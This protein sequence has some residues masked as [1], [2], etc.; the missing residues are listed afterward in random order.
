[1]F[2]MGGRSEKKT[3]LQRQRRQRRREQ[4]PLRRA[5]LLNKEEREGTIRVLVGE[6]EQE[7]KEGRKNQ[8]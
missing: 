5:S 1:M 6:P 7:E 3:Y 2:E 8:T 4:E